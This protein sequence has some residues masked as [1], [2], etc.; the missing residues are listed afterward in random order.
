VGSAGLDENCNANHESRQ[1]LG[2]CFL[3]LDALLLALRLVRLEQVS[4]QF[5]E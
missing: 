1:I 4:V 3:L 2:L 5:Q